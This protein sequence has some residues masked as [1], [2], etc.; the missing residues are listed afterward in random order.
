MLLTKPYPFDLRVKKETKSLLAD[1][2]GVT[3]LCR[4]GTADTHR[5][6]VDGVTVYRYAP[7]TTSR[8]LPDKVRYLLTQVHPYWAG[9]L[10]EVVEAENI[11]AIHVH[12]LRFADTALAVGKQ[13]GLPVVA[14]LHEN[15]PEA[16]RQW[17]RMVEWPVLVRHPAKLADRLG[18]PVARYKRIERRCVRRADRL[19]CV[20]EEAREHY[21]RDCDGDPKK[22]HVVSNRVDLSLLDQ[23]DIQPIEH[24]GFLVSYIGSYGAHRGLKTAIKA[25]SHVVSEVPEA[26][27]LIV[28]SA[29][30]KDYEQEIKDFCEKQNVRENVSFTG[31]VDFE[32]VPSYIAA[33]DVCFV[34]HSETAH[35]NTTIPHKL[36]QYMALRRPTI[37]SDVKPLERV[38]EDTN[39]GLVI[40]AGDDKAMANAVCKLYRHPE[41]RANLGENG[42]QAVEDRYNWENEASELQDV[43]RGLTDSQYS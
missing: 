41:I 3:V 39:S 30:E 40:P 16:V 36:F 35:T 21:L 15:Y 18:F 23:I 17:R 1:G 8:S 20:A 25:I 38:V 10:R 28:G 43:Y 19:I 14:D 6:V 9:A 11:D 12:D 24:D 42:R 2:H 37:V 22:I 5:E 26:R 29:G 33:S 4:Q 32:C 31:W 27:L 7:S 13:Y 34:T